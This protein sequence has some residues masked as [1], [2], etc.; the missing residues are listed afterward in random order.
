MSLVMRGFDKQEMSCSHAVDLAEGT[1][2]VTG[3]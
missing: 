3:D 1:G 2:M